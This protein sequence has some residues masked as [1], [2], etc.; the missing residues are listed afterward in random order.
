MEVFSPSLLVQISLATKHINNMKIL[1]W[2]QPRCLKSFFFAFFSSRNPFLSIFIEDV[3]AEDL[4]YLWMI[5]FGWLLY[6]L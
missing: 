6:R 1:F 3:F 4:E 2:K 5:M